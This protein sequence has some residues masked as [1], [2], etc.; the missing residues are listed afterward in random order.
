VPTSLLWGAAQIRAF[1]QVLAAS[2]DLAVTVTITIA[3]LV[4][5]VY[6][7]S[8]GLL[9]DA[10]TDL[11]QGIALTL[12]LVILMI[13][14]LMKQGAAPFTAVE[15]QRLGLFAGDT[16]ILGRIEAYAIPALGS[17][18]AAELVSR[19]IA[20][21]TPQVAKRSALVAAAVYLVIGFIP[22]AI[23][24]IG[25]RLVPDLT[26]AEHVLPLIAQQHL[27][28]LLYVLLAGALVSAILSTVDSSLL[29][30]ASM[31]SHNILVPLRPRM[32][33]AARVRAARTWVAVFGLLAYVL[34][35]HAEGVY[36]LVEEA[37]AFGSAGVF[38][39]A[40]LGLFTRI[41]GRASAFAALATGVAAWI[42]GAHAFQLPYPYL[43]SLGA[44]LIAYLVPAWWQRQR[45][46]G[47]LSGSTA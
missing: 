7:M 37:S 30:A 2:S 40:L 19:V 16:P 41:G 15:P 45:V 11:V 35:L 27:P 47:S 34:A 6:T 23:G 25:P 10:Y 44:A 1:G 39:V 32:S 22:A 29:C 26:D 28:R 36:A 38:V 5:I 8:G 17:A 3:A 18:F 46:A 31:T 33:D 42:L 24:L 9:A 4:V 20:T 13:A 12:G 43:T 21:R 14:V